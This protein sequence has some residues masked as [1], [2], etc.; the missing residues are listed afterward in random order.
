MNKLWQ[1]AP[2]NLAITTGELHL[3]RCNLDCHDFGCEPQQFLSTDEIVRSERLL[4]HSKQQ[5]FIT[6]RSYL[7]FIIGKY[8]Q[9]APA[10]VKF[11]YNQHGKPYLELQ[12]N[13]TLHFNL[14]HSGSYAVIAITD[15]VEVGVDIEKIETELDYWQLANSYFSVAEKDQLSKIIS[16]RQ[17]LG[18]YQLWTQKEALMK[19]TGSGFS[20]NDSG[21]IE[22]ENKPNHYLENFLVT[23]GYTAAVAMPQIV[24]PYEPLVS[25]YDLYNVKPS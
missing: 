7:R 2:D 11:D 19:M 13:S 4:N 5:Q 12:L 6:A 21:V 15:G 10:L 1:T 16:A 22:V 3:W 25:C 24:S 17:R 20:G 9:L 18:F 14:S 8:L 23:D